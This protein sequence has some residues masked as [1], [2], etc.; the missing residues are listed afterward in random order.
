MTSEDIQQLNSANQPAQQVNLVSDDDL[1]V[2][3]IRSI[4]A[5]PYIRVTHGGFGINFNFKPM[6]GAPET[7]IVR[8]IGDGKVALLLDEN[9]QI[10]GFR[11]EWPGV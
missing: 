11:L 10:I 1:R 6:M 4:V 9:M 3:Y 5:H 2:D 7:V 8:Y